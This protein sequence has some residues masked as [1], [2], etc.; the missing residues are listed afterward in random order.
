[1]LSSMLIICL[2]VLFYLFFPVKRMP[3]TNDNTICSIK[4]DVGLIVG[5]KLGNKEYY[6]YNSDY[7][8]KYENGVSSPLDY[9]IHSFYLQFKKFPSYNLLYEKKYE[10]LS[11]LKRKSSFNLAYN[12]VII[13]DTGIKS[14][15]IQRFNFY[16]TNDIKF[17][18][19]KSENIKMIEVLNGV[20]GDSIQLYRGSN[21]P[22]DAVY[23][24]IKNEYKAE[25]IDMI[26]KQEIINEFLKM[27]KETQSSDDFSRKNYLSP[28]VYYRISFKDERFQMWL[29]CK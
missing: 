6:V 4:D 25:I 2:V 3:I 16:K 14:T 28:N 19:F 23:Q 8:Y 27:Y 21:S 15:A 9:N 17:P 10:S 29:V 26:D 22:D 12:N 5:Y 11:D 20:Y 18:V 7:T 24:A 1:M 13:E